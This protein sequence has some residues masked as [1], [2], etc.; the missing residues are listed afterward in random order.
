MSSK[1]GR[2]RVTLGFG[3]LAIVFATFAG[4]MSAIDAA[5]L[6]SAPHSASDQR[7]PNNPHAIGSPG[8]GYWLMSDDGG[9]YSFGS[10]M[11]FGSMSNRTLEKPTVCMSSSSNGG[12]YWLVST[13]GG[14]FSFG[15]ANFYGSAGSTKL[16]APIVGMSPSNDGAGYW[17]A[18]SD[19]GVFSYGDS[20][21]KGSMATRSLSAPVVAIAGLGRPGGCLGT[22]IPQK[23]SVPDTSGP[24]GEGIWIPSGRLVGSTPAIYETILRPHQGA[25]A[26]GIAWMDQSRIITRLYAG[27][28]GQPPGTYKY[29]GSVSPVDRPKLLAA[30]NSGFL[31]GQSNGG[32]Y[33]EGQTPLPLVNGAASAVIY[34]N[35]TVRVGMWGRDFTMTP[36]VV[37]VR[38]NLSMLVDGG[39]AA[40]DLSIGSWGA[41]IAGMAYD[42]RSGLGTD[43][44]GNLIYVAGSD[45]SPTDLAH[46]LIAAGAVEAMQLDINPQWP[47]YSTYATSPGQPNPANV[48]GWNLISGMNY[49]PNLFLA[50]NGRDFFSIFSN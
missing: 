36:D 16:A 38:Q 49:S 14:V 7:Q 1:G 21:Y 26:S 9:V 18:G 46:L 15:N 25:P 32:W 34:S 20:S 22:A 47:I 41:V 44:F 50:G 2:R 39:V 10:S 31:M 28:P 35:G 40:P 23:L 17:L 30:F 43:R 12:G 42:W 48:T 29:S 4:N 37:S 33:S 5:T 3:I 13:D 24:P 45:L 6:N 27:I 19:G 11:F 8:D